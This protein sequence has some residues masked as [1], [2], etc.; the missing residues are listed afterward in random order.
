MISPRFPR[1]YFAIIFPAYLV[2]ICFRYRTLQPPWTSDYFTAKVN[3]HFVS[4]VKTR[5]SETRTRERRSGP[6]AEKLLGESVCV[7]VSRPRFCCVACI[8]PRSETQSKEKDSVPGK[9]VKPPRPARPGERN[10]S[11]ER[12]LCENLANHILRR[13]NVRGISV[14]SCLPRACLC[15]KSTLSSDKDRGTRDLSRKRRFT[16]NGTRPLTSA[17]T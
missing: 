17:R 12:K 10:K 8:A 5:R 1:L 4:E 16:Q 11:Q 7:I 3:H 15:H 2:L 6:R 14:A 13:G 9:R